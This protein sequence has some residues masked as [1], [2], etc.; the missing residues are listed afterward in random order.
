M[1]F[2]ELMDLI[3]CHKQF[4]GLTKNKIINVEDEEDTEIDVN[5]PFYKL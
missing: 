3:E 5:D 4:L 2:C 1:R